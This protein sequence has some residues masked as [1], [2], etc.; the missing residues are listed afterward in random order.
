MAVRSLS[1]ESPYPASILQ[2]TPSFLRS[3]TWSLPS[4]P[5]HQGT[6]TPC[7]APRNRGR[8]AATT[9][10]SPAGRGLGPGGRGGEGSFCFQGTAAT[11]TTQAADPTAA[12]EVGRGEWK[13]G[14]VGKRATRKRLKS[15]AAVN[16]GRWSPRKLETGATEKG[17]TTNPRTTRPRPWCREAPEGNAPGRGVGS[18]HWKRKRST[19]FWAREPGKYSR[20]ILSPWG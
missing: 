15:C 4:P 7:A 14:R 11:A 18:R 6:E 19:V 16:A 9:S 2:T 20:V 17:R 12:G 5:P 13:L 8:G 1:R 3:R 10:D